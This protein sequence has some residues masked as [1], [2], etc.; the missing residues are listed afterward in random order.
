MLG[1]RRSRRLR[2]SDID[3]L[4]GDRDRSSR[5]DLRISSRGGLRPTK[6]AFESVVEGTKTCTTTPIAFDPDSIDLTGA[7]AGDDGGIYYV[8]QLDSAIWWNGMS[9][10]D[11]GP[12]LLGR[13]WN[14]VCR[15]EISEDLT[16]ASEWA[17]VPRGGIDGSGDGRFQ[18]RCR[19]GGQPPS[20]QDGRN[21]LRP[22]HTVRTPA[23]WASPSKRPLSQSRFERPR[24]PSVSLSRRSEH[25]EPGRGEASGRRLEAAHRPLPPSHP[26]RPGRCN[27]GTSSLPHPC[28]QTPAALPSRPS[29]SR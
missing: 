15:G 21:G 27:G 5:G 19:R 18:D 13:H 6:P 7:W 10:R 28:G 23:S 26:S 25:A 16:I 8:R 24:S 1:C 3:R 17:D 20:H 2:W 12:A 14:N 11:E 4:S 9:S 29:T 22:R